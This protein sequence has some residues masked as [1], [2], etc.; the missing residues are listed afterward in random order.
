MGNE[1]RFDD[2][3][4]LLNE[5]Q[6][7][8]IDPPIDVTL[9]GIVIVVNDEQDLN[10]DPP[11][12]VTLSGMLIDVKFE[13]FCKADP[14]ILVALFVN[15]ASLNCVLPEKDDDEQEVH[16]AAFHVIF[17]AL[18]QPLKALSPIVV[19]PLGIKILD[20]LVQYLNASLLILRMELGKYIDSNSAQLIKPLLPTSVTGRPS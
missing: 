8:S 3:T 19:T 7:E 1:E 6:P 18:V 12:D 9:L 15:T 17:V 16:A 11:I 20:K 4:T 14:G 2:K 13:Q 5:V 10:A